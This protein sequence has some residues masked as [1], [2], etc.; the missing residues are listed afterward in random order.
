MDIQDTKDFYEGQT[1]Q[2]LKN[3]Y[4]NTW[5]EDDEEFEL[6]EHTYDE[7][8]DKIQDADIDQVTEWLNI[9]EYTVFESLED[10]QEF[11]EANEDL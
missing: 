6:G 8:M 4:S 11:I 5:D 2:D 9:M 1:L 10:M 7:F 3:F